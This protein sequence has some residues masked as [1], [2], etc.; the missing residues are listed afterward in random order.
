MT[1]LQ[2]T[3]DLDLLLAILPPR[4]HAALEAANRASEL[5]EVIMDVGRLPRRALPKGASFTSAI[6][7]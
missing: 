3:D 6:R 5:I 2:I 4:I 7:K 1:T